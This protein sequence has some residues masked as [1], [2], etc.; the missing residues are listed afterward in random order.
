MSHGDSIYPRSVLRQIIVLV[1]SIVYLLILYTAKT[2]DMYTQAFVTT[3][4]RGVTD[5]SGQ[6]KC[7][8][9]QEHLITI[10]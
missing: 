9:F 4:D 5:R 8:P 10:K 1:L 3:L 7:L 6:M 2:K